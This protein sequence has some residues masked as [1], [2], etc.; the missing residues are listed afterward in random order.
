MTSLIVVIDS[1]HTL[2]IVSYAITIDALTSTLHR[3][4]EASRSSHHLL[5]ASV[6]HLA[7]DTALST[8]FYT[9]LI[10]V[11]HIKAVD[12]IAGYVNVQIRTFFSNCVVMCI[13][14]HFGRPKLQP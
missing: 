11:L 13:F 2:L 12:F 14:D 3:G 9:N 1:V 4:V 7:L 5:D 10:A 6:S 8:E